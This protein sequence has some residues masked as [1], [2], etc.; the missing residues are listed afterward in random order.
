SYAVFFMKNKSSSGQ[1]LGSFAVTNKNEWDNEYGNI[2]KV[3][4]LTAFDYVPKSTE[5]G[6]TGWHKIRAEKN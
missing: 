2:Y 6:R 1:V 3:N 4:I 5:L